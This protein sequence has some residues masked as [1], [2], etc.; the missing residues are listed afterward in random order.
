[1]IF[2]F[3]MAMMAAE[4]PAATL[5]AN[6][7]VTL[8][9]VASGEFGSVFFGDTV[10]TAKGSQAVLTAPNAM[11]LVPANSAVTLDAERVQVRAGA[12]VVT[13]SRKL[14][15]Q[16]KGVTVTPQAAQTTRFAVRESGN[17]IEVAALRGTVL[18]I[19]GSA[20]TALTEGSTVSLDA[21]SP[22]PQAS[23]PATG[24]SHFVG[25][26]ELGII[27]AVVGAVTAGVIVGVVNSQKESS[28]SIP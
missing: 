27:L 22:A 8:N 19:E 10:A 17:K 23:V 15:A 3:P 4:T 12:A 16:V 25:G 9:G 11:V 21:A 2:V 14:G 20:T 24:G 7:P 1:M 6:G 18:I 5:R 13:T 26:P 28:P